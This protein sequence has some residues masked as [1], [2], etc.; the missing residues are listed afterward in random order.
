LET[1]KT[2]CTPPY[3]SLEQ[4]KGDEAEPYFD[5]W[6]VGVTIYRMM[7]GK[8]PKFIGMSFDPLPTTYS[9]ELR[10]LVDKLLTLHPYDRLTVDQ[11]LR[12]PIISKALD[13]I[14]DD[15]VALTSDYKTSRD[16]HKLLVAIMKRKC[17]EAKT[18]YNGLKIGQGTVLKVANIKGNEWMLPIELDSINRGLKF[19]QKLYEDGMYTGYLNADD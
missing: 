18:P 16:A 2:R 13:K 15:L 7:A 17:E 9:Q 10:D 11:V 4:L 6:A 19:G 12:S 14:I 5:M 1:I 3:A 8:L